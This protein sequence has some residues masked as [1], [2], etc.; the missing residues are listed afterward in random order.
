M[1]KTI[2]DFLMNHK[3][4]NPVSFHMP[5]HK[6][7]TILYKKYGYEDFVRGM[8]GND[9]TEIP[10]A[11]A[12]QQPQSVIRDVMDNYAAIYGAKHTELLVNGSSAGLM[13]A[14]LTAVPRG[15][16]LIMG[17]N[18]HK[19]IFGAVRLGGIQPVYVRPEIHRKYEL[20]GA[21]TAKSIRRSL[22]AN[23][24]ASAV[25][26][27]SPNYYGVL[28]DIGGI[29]SVCHEYG[30]ILIVDQA[31][32][33]HLKFF[34]MGSG[35]KTAAENLGAD[36]VINSTHKTL[37]T[38][39]GSAILNVCSDRVNIDD[40]ADNLRMLQTTSP[41]YLMMG[42]LDVNQKILAKAGREL[43]QVWKS[44][45]RYFYSKASEI[46]GVDVIMGPDLDLTKINLTMI[47]MGL[48]GNDLEEELRRHNIWVEM[49]HGD[50]VM[51]M[52]G[53]GNLRF[54]YDA[55]LAALS[56]ISMKYGVSSGRVPVRDPMVAFDL[57]YVGVPEKKE[58]IS[59]Y[60]AEGRVVYDEITPYPPGVPVACPGEVLNFEVISFL[61]RLIKRG[62][63][64]IGVDD[65]GCVNVGAL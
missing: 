57:E 29:A 19:S 23:P 55:A 12:L 56:E 13:A 1:N 16:K 7:R 58:R 65:E 59:L 41:S 8:F 30:K 62:D 25:L 48:D 21:V 51:L 36:I 9:I 27:T 47:R 61:E 50:Y 32:G 20:Q 17:R 11:D 26:I 5:G 39:T 4:D 45:L 64:V 46:P 40:L 42:T 54:D 2:A 15:C 43:I 3:K 28:S 6:G 10:G 35:K 22:E 34:D 60:N 14:V 18:S 24:D 31:H 44:D 52:T 37:L 33:A 38:F 53:L 49:V 63:S